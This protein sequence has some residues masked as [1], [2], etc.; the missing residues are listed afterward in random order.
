MSIEQEPRQTPRELDRPG[1]IIWLS[2]SHLEPGMNLTKLEFLMAQYGLVE[3]T[4]WDKITD[5]TLDAMIAQ[6]HE[7]AQ[8]ALDDVPSAA[9]AYVLEYL[10]DKPGEADSLKV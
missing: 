1:K 4:T 5:E 7:L 2:Q 3:A 9:G 6:V 10:F 8:V